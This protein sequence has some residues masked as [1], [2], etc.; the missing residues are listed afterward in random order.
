MELYQHECIINP[1]SSGL[2]LSRKAVCLDK[3]KSISS[4]VPCKQMDTTD[5]LNSCIHQ[6]LN[7][8]YQ[9]NYNWAQTLGHIHRITSQSNILRRQ[10]LKCFGK[11]SP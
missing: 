9:R 8:K 11:I 2:Y 5:F 1:I 10:L 6:F 4:N 3:R 7:S